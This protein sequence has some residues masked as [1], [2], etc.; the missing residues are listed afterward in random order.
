MKLGSKTQTKKRSEEVFCPKCKNRGQRIFSLGKED[1]VNYE[2]KFCGNKWTQNTITSFLD[3]KGD[4][5]PDR[6]ECGGRFEFD[7]IDGKTHYDIFKCNKCGVKNT[8]E[9]M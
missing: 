8:P 7:H 3:N 9:A 2:C 1:V 5:D 4:L 6:C